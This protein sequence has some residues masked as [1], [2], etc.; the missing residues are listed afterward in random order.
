MALLS[1]TLH[2]ACQKNSQGLGLHISPEQSAEQT[3]ALACWL[4]WMFI[5][6][7]KVDFKGDL[8]WLDLNYNVFVLET[9]NNTFT[10]NCLTKQV[11]NQLLFISV[12]VVVNL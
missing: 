5:L 8:Q 4:L 9:F 7:Y 6:I 2:L 11:N 12:Y 10:I 1:K 3:Q